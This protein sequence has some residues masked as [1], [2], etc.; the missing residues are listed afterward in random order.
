MKL[1][2]SGLKPEAFSQTSSLPDSKRKAEDEGDGVTREDTKSISLLVSIITIY[3][4]NQ[5]AV[6]S[7][8][9]DV[10]KLTPY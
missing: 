10:K 2:K 1:I 4:L 9:T 7:N 5:L 3:S 8:K 6:R